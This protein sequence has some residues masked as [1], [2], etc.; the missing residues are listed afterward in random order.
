MNPTEVRLV[1]YR[2]ENWH[3]DHITFHLEKERKFSSLNPMNVLFVADDASTVGK[4]VYRGFTSPTLTGLMGQFQ[5][6]FW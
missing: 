2:R 3:Y 6:Q 5:G 1:H 4:P